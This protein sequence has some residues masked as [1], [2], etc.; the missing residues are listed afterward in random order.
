MA[1]SVYVLGSSA[2]KA[3]LLLDEVCAS[4]RLVPVLAVRPVLGRSDRW[5]ARAALAGEKPLARRPSS[6]LEYRLRRGH[7]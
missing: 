3:Q 5:E 7:R 4:G 6:A 2:E 1:D